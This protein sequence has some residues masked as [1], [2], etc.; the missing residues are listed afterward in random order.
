VEYSNWKASSLLED[1]AMSTNV[2]SFV[3]VNCKIKIFYSYRGHVFFNLSSLLQQLIDAAISHRQ[4]HSFCVC[5]CTILL[6]SGLT[7]FPLRN[8]LRDLIHILSTPWDILPTSYFIRLQ[9]CAFSGH[10]S[11]QSRVDN[12]SKISD[13]DGNCA[14]QEV[15]ET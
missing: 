2:R 11:P 13:R 14:R 1:G 5:F 4:A 9:P 12:Q 6:S 10:L 15:A 7:R 8:C 3:D